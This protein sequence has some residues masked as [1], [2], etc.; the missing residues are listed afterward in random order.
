MGFPRLK[1]WR[2]VYL[3]D[4]DKQ[5]GGYDEHYR[6]LAL[7]AYYN[8]SLWELYVNDWIIFDNK[9]Y[10]IHTIKIIV[11]DDVSIYD[12]DY[13]LMVITCLNMFIW[14]KRLVIEANLWEGVQIG[15]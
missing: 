2:D 13:D 12:D 5:D 15:L 8:I 11:P 4:P 1:L 14:D 6:T 3:G 7:H 10:R 9:W